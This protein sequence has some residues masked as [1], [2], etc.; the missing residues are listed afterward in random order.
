MINKKHLLLAF[1]VTLIGIC[2]YLIIQETNTDTLILLATNM[3][4]WTIVG[5]FLFLMAAQTLSAFRSSWYFRSVGVIFNPHFSIGLYFTG[6]LYNTILPGGIGGD[7][8]KLFI[9]G[10]WTSLKR[11]T[12]FRI[13][14]SERASGLY[15]LLFWCTL[16]FLLS[17]LD[18]HIPLGPLLVILAFIITTATYFWCTKNILKE[19]T[20]TT[21]VAAHY[22]F[23]IQLL[24]IFSASLLLYGLSHHTVNWAEFSAY[25]TIFLISNI[26]AILPISVA[27]FGIR[28]VTFLYASVYFGLHKETG[29]ALGLMYFAIY[30]FMALNGLFFWHKLEK[31][32]HKTSS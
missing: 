1:K 15:L 5:A 25:I 4:P 30:T 29:I 17:N 27:G 13:L 12:I 31:L 28:E 6:S 19:K 8:Y 3:P 11:K 26:L 9:L 24:Y 2:L 23:W 14:L 20:T 18:H 10:K 16:F 22:S 21:I 7:G 32:F